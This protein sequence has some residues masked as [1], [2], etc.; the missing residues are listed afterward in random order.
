[1]RVEANH[2]KYA[3]NG[4]A[5]GLLTNFGHICHDLDEIWR[6]DPRSEEWKRT[7]GDDSDME[8]WKVSI[9]QLIQDGLALKDRHS[10][11]V[12]HKYEIIIY[13]SDE[14]DAFVAEALE[15]PGCAAHGDTQ[16]EALKHIGEAVDMWIETS[17]VRRPNPR[18]EGRECLM[19]A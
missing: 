10:L 12:M 7:S 2:K 15:L 3:V 19:L 6:D 11:S 14:D 17:G 16:E 9:H 4:I 1:M 18:A 8:G 5:K 13:W